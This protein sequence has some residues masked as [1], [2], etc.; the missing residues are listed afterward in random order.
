MEIW[1]LSTYCQVNH[2]STEKK[3]NIKCPYIYIYIYSIQYTPA[4]VRA[5]SV[6]KMLDIMGRIFYLWIQCNGLSTKGAA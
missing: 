1:S 5:L 2:N 4:S 6:M 3:K